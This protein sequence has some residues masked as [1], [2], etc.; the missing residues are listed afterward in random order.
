MDIESTEALDSTDIRC[1]HTNESQIH[2]I[3]QRFLA[4]EMTKTTGAGM[5]QKAV[6]NSK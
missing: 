4:E 6:Y 2:T 5:V 1:V 3:V